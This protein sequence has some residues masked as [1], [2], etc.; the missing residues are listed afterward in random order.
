MLPGAMCLMVLAGSAMITKTFP[1][2]WIT[3]LITCEVSAL[4]NRAVPIPDITGAG[5]LPA[6]SADRLT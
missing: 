1:Y 2:M 5:R 3:Q 6:Q 4:M